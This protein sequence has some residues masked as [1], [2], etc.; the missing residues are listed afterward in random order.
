M[1]M[2]LDIYGKEDVRNILRATYVASEGSAALLSEVLRDPELQQIS[3]GKL[4]RIYRQGFASAVGA[5]GLAFGLDG[6]P[7]AHE[8]EGEHTL[9]QMDVRAT[10]AVAGGQRSLSGSGA[11]PELGDLDLGRFLWTKTQ[12]EQRR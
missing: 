3:L 8:L 10:S 4:L 2:A 12:H 9:I 7:M 11:D 1:T 5:I 6:L